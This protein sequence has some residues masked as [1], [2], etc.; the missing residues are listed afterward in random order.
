MSTG[1]PPS[2]SFGDLPSRQAAPSLAS[3]DQG[4]V[5]AGR[6][7]IQEILG[8]G[9]V[10]RVYAAV[11]LSIGRRVALKV[12]LEPLNERHRARFVIEAEVTA[13]LRHPGIVAVHAGGVAAEGYPFLVMELVEHAETMQ[14]HLQRQPE[15]GVELLLQV[16]RAVGYAHDKGISHRDLKP[17]NVLVDGNGRA[18]VCDFGLARRDHA[19]RLTRTGEI[20]G[21]PYY[22]APERFESK[23]DHAHGPQGDV[24][25]LGVMLYEV[26]TGKL[27][28][29]PAQGGLLELIV[30][31]CNTDSEAPR[32]LDPKI[33]PA[34]EKVVLRALRKPPAERY[35]QADALAD[36]LEEAELRTDGLRGRRG[37]VALLAIGAIGVVGGVA[38][39]WGGSPPAERRP[40]SQ[41]LGAG[42]EAPPPP[43]SPP[44]PEL[45]AAEQALERL[46][47]TAHELRGYRDEVS[48]AFEDLAWTVRSDPQL[49]AR[50]QLEHLAYLYRRGRW[51]RVK[52][53]APPL[54]QDGS[55]V[56]AQ[57][58]LIHGL[59][60]VEL[61]ERDASEEHFARHWAR[62][63][64][65]TQD[66]IELTIGAWH[67]FYGVK[68]HAEA[69]RL[70]L[71]AQELDPYCT[72]AL[73]A[74]GLLRGDTMDVQAARQLLELAASREPDDIT[75]VRGLTLVYQS[76]G[77]AD[78]TLQA[79]RTFLALQEPDPEV[80]TLTHAATLF[81]NEEL[82]QEAA[83]LC[84][85][86]V[87]REPQ[88]A[89]ARLLLGL[90]Y[91]VLGDARGPEVMWQLNADDP[92]QLWVELDQTAP[93]L[94]PHVERLLAQDPRA[95]SR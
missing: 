30:S 23:P 68:D 4:A 14:D 74:E 84:E 46:L 33:H 9:G 65:E 40:D 3:L 39:T 66:P 43:D 8:Q 82:Y 61:L 5:F 87:A 17:S 15:R 27:P 54:E 49:L 41:E 80:I 85:R 11:D 26:L 32:T 94:R 89:R 34:L 51:T 6:Y 56:A 58:V 62:W 78:L 37:K 71:R 13:S 2:W 24:W 79:V 95:G 93:E 1:H 73:I 70:A 28:F 45:A 29:Q 44:D 83:E 86:A 12:L 48:L 31:I 16:A 42:D 53:M 21:T 77:D 72:P 69:L 63:G 60:L 20:L 75:A 88:H 38:A 10:G 50:V 91:L 81:R 59:S 57:A 36:A 25:A 76:V 52:A 22:M 67:H 35:P 19:E 55:P 47:V 7:Q 18:R 64:P 92:S 90:S